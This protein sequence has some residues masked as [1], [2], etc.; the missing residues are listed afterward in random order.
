[1]LTVSAPAKVNLVL[2]VLGKRN[3]GYHEIR[4]LIQTI[5]LCD[6]LSF[7]ADSAI[8]L[9]CTEPVLQGSD[10]LVIRAAE[11][12]KETG[13]C[14]QGARIKLVKQIPSSAGL[15][16]GSSDAAATLLALNS[17]WKL[18]FKTSDLISLAARLGSDVPFYIHG[19]MALVKGRGEKVIP[20]P[21]PLSNWFVLLLPS[22]SEMPQKTKQ[23]YARL[24]DQHFTEGEFISKAMQSWL[25][26]S[27]IS[28]SLL[29]NVFDSIAFDTFPE[30]EEYWKRFEQAGAS[31][32]HLAG[33]GPA[34][35]TVVDS[36]NSAEGLY[37]CLCSQ[38]LKA[39]YA[40]AIM[41]KGH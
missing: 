19:G 31:D 10:N 37:K 6:T 18:E 21:T 22:L 27:E 4:S 38:N 5:D 3:D 26:N 15:G 35:F 39:Y 13:G 20:L 41:P 16:G 14:R 30:L 36:Q 23:L 34:L 9:D 25:G 8:S 29:F 7:E 28:S 2:E 32:I 24:N 1:M 40:S 33:S 17:F 11:L 12:L